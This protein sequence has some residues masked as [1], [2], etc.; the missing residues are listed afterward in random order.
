MSSICIGDRLIGGGQP[1]FLV[2]EI[3]INLRKPL[4][5]LLMLALMQSNFKIIGLRISF[6]INL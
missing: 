6:L 3:G 2:A 1:C 5:Q 4:M